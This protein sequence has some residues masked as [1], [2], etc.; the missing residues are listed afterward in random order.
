[1]FARAG[2]QIAGEVA[3]GI[4]D[5][6]SAT[7]HTLA[8]VGETVVAGVEDAAATVVGGVSAVGDAVVDVASDIAD[9]AMTVVDDL[10][11]FSW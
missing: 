11:P 4:A 3:T 10:N 7:V 8:A 5:A 2:A 9:G 1:M 6:A